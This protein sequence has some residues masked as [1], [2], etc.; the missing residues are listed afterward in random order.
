M[1]R[2][3]ASA[4]RPAP[5]AIELVGWAEAVGHLPEI[6]LASQQTPGASE[7]HFSVLRC[8]SMPRNVRERWRARRVSGTR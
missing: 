5:Q 8:R 6:P 3:L 2:R 4:G 1:N 7:A